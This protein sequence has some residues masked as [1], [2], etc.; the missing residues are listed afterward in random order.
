MSSYRGVLV[1]F[2]S[3]TFRATVRLDASP[4]QSTPNLPVS[5]AIP[6][7]EMVAGRRILIDMGDGHDAE[8]MVVMAVW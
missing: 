5:R 8:E 4:G 6:A 3:P 1:S 2:D 7:A